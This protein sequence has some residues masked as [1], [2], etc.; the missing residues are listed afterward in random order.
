MREPFQKGR[1]NADIGAITLFGQAR[2][3][4]ARFAEHQ[5]F[6]ANHLSGKIANHRFEA[7]RSN[8]LPRYENKFS[9]ANRF[10]EETPRFAL[11]IARPSKYE[12][13]YGNAHES[14]RECVHERYMSLC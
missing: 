4:P 5:L 2:F 14:V 11:R 1:V 3:A 10:A 13:V 9:S 7:I 8:R 12:S 6:I